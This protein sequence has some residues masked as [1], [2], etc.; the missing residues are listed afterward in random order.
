M[1]RL[2]GALE[3][4][5]AVRS[6]SLTAL[7]VVSEALE[8]IGSLDS[9]TNAFTVVLE[10]EALAAAAEVDRLV[11]SGARP[12]LAGVPVGV[13][14]H[15]W[16]AG[17]PATDGSRVL[18]GFVPEVSAAAVARLV[19]AGAVVVGKTNNP[20]FCYAGTTDSPLFGKTH[21][22]WGL[23]RTPGGSS[24]GSG[25]ALAA[26]L[27]TLAVGT[28]GGGSIRIPAG[29]CGIV[30][31]KPTKGA[32]PT[33]PGFS[34]WPT[35]SVHG[36]MGR[37]VADVAL[38]FEVMA[39]PHPSDPSTV[40]SGALLPARPPG[41]SPL[42]GLRVAACPVIAGYQPDPA[43][44]EAFR[45]AMDACAGL[46][47]EIEELADPFGPELGDLWNAIAAA[48]SFA[49][50]G[51]YLENPEITPLS[52]AMLRRGA[53]MPLA[54]YLGAQQQRRELSTLAA[55]LLGRFDV[56]VS[57]G[58]PVVAFPLGREEPGERE[59]DDAWWVA[60]AVANLT[61]QPATAVPIGLAAPGLP[62]GVQVL[63]PRFADRLTLA[64]AAE[65]EAAVERAGLWSPGSDPT[66]GWPG[67]APST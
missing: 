4:A 26:G 19:E 57:P 30:G 31:H 48:E 50:Q 25:A 8:R 63:G 24:G 51:E 7:R 17:A 47:W 2:P 27:V 20:E 35:L 32:V 6:R 49:S 55:E 67:R 43:V 59:G 22:P 40:P 15:V 52:R 33:L 61:N 46:G 18:E 60:N 42:A 62:V 39:G 41:D 9:E 13:K 11:E 10:E 16:L 5:E 44:G 53:A 56:L 34:G 66:L 38:M 36:P 54:E 64:V 14:D 28:D 29:F 23:S 3:T 21:N 58:Q 1:N 45:W 37:N 65:I 12:V